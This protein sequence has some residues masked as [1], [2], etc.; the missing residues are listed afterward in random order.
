MSCNSCGAQLIF[1]RYIRRGD[2][3][4]YPKSSK[5]FVW[6]PNGCRCTSN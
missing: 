5:A 6:C 2:R 3:V 4:I 1:A